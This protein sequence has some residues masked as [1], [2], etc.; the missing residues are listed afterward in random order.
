MKD[1]IVWLCWTKSNQQKYLKVTAILESSRLSLN[2][3]HWKVTAR[4]EELMLSLSLSLYCL[5]VIA[6]LED[7]TLSLNLN[8]YR[9]KATAKLERSI[10]VLTLG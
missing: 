7:S 10:L 1:S 4:L 5:K 9:L 8:S 6:I 2:L 3:Y